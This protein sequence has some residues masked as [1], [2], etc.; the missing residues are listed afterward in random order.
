MLKLLKHLKQ[1]QKIGVDFFSVIEEILTPVAPVLGGALVLGIYYLKSEGLQ[2]SKEAEEYVIGAAQF[3]VKTQDRLLFDKVYE[4]EELLSSWGTGNL[5]SD[6]KTSLKEALEEYKKEVRDKAV[7]DL[8]TEIKSSKFQKTVK[9]MVGDN[10]D[11]LINRSLTE[12]EVN[13]VIK[14]K[15]C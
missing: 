9:S 5:I 3:V 11:P 4:N 2:I 15:K 7:S 10:I 14:A 13:K 1:N 12:N 6:G 8:P